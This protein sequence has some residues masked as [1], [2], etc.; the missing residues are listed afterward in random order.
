[1]FVSPFA[2][3]GGHFLYAAPSH[4]QRSNHA[5]FVLGVAGIGAQLLHA[6]SNQLVRTENPCLNTVEGSY[7]VPALELETALALEPLQEGSASQPHA[8]VEQCVTV[9]PAL[10]DP[11][12]SVEPVL[13]CEGREPRYGGEQFPRLCITSIWIARRTIPVWGLA[14][15]SLLV[16]PPFPLHPRRPITK[17]NVITPSSSLPIPSLSVLPSAATDAHWLYAPPSH[18]DCVISGYRHTRA[19]VDEA[20][21]PGGYSR[22][23]L[24][25]Y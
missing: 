13:D 25:R 1:M 14:V 18:L 20:S 8:D 17:L 6:A 16:I 23:V 9:L 22:T 24:S 15:L 10:H 5:Q 19:E 12:V 21:G 2:A 7:L 3:V 4:S 11:V